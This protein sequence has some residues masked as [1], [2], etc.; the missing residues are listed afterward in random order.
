M[1]QRRKNF[2]LNFQFNEMLKLSTIVNICFKET[3]GIEKTVIN[4]Y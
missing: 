2:F 3:L 4:H 1:F